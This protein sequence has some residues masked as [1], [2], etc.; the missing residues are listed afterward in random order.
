LSDRSPAVKANSQANKPEKKNKNILA[1]K[2][3]GKKN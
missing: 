1:R 2:K 3:E